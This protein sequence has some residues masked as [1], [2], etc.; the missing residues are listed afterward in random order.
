MTVFVLFFNAAEFN[1]A[2][3][4]VATHAR[5]LIVFFLP[6]FWLTCVPELLVPIHGEDDQEVAQDV[7][8]DSE[9]EEAPQSCGNPRRAVQDGV[10]GVWRGA[11]QVRPIYNHCT[12]S[13]NFLNWPK[14]NVLSLPVRP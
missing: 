6:D 13:L 7:N 8:D 12:Q 11:V 4:S 10:T 3:C 9:D 5:T 2:P 14:F 1:R